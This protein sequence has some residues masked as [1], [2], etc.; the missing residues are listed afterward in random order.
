MSNTERRVVFCN[1]APH[2]HVEDKWSIVYV[3]EWDEYNEEPK[4]FSFAP[5]YFYSAIDMIGD[6]DR[7]WYAPPR[8]FAMVCK[9]K[10]K[11]W[12]V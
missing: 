6:P 8:N 3:N 9:K 1:W 12:S 11:L 7:G 10:G 2:P 4:E 5:S